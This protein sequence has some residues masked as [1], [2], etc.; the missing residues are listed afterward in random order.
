[1]KPRLDVADGRTRDPVRRGRRDGTAITFEGVRFDGLL[2]IVDDAAFR[3]G[4]IHGIGP[5]KAF[6]F[7]LLSFAPI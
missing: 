3:A 7:G 6:G 1:M 2:R 4:V 5:D